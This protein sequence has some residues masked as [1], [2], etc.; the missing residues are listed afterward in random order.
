[1]AALL[2][3]VLQ[4]PVGASRRWLRRL[5]M[6]CLAFLS[7]GFSETA[8]M[9]QAGLFA[10]GVALWTA[11]RSRPRSNDAGGLLLAGLGGTLIGLAVMVLAPGN[12]YRQAFFPPAP[13]L[14]GL[15]RLATL[16]FLSFI[17]ITLL[18]EAGW[19]ARVHRWLSLATVYR[20][21]RLLAE[22]GLVRELHFDEEHHH[23]ERALGEHYH[24]H[25]VQCGQVVEIWPPDGGAWLRQV[26]ASAGF[27]LA[28]VRLVR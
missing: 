11:G 9:V 8:V 13:G 27:Q 20:T 6:A 14:F 18:W 16:N 7:T 28:T 17:K 10:I 23:Y 22:M 4:E 1:M 3:A 5:A 25:C 15:L 24:L 2:L 26:A 21:L 12:V 19:A